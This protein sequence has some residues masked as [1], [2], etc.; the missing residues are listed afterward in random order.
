MTEEQLNLLDALKQTDEYSS[1]I[2]GTYSFRGE[3][4]ETEVLPRLQSL[5]VKNTTVL[6]DTEKYKNTD[7]LVHAGNKYYLDHVRCPQTFHP[8]FLLLLG[9]RRGYCLVGS[10]NLSAAGWQH[11]AELMTEF[12]YNDADSD[13]E[14]AAVFDQL[15]G[16]IDGITTNSRV[17]SDK[18]Q[19]AIEEAMRD[20]P[21]LEEASSTHDASNVA[22]IDNLSTPIIDQ[23]SERIPQQ[24]ITEIEVISPYFS[25]NDIQVIQSLCQLNPDRLILN[26]Q[27]NRVQGFDA[28][29]IIDAVP[30]STEL[31]VQAIT[32]GE[33]ENRLIHGKL[34]MLRGTEDVWSLYGSPNLTTA[35]LALPATAGN[36]ELAVLRHET[37]PDYFD[38]LLD[39][40]VINRS[41][42]DPTAI[43]YEPYDTLDDETSS[44]TL[45]LS[46]AH[47]ETDGLLILGVD[48]FTAE[49]I[50]IHLEK[51]QAETAL[52]ISKTAVEVVDGTLE[53]Q[54]ERIP[55]FC[56]GATQVWL[57]LHVE[58][59]EQHTDS[60]WIARPSLEVTPRTSEV[61]QIEASKGRNGLIDL[62][63]RLEGIHAMYDFLD[64]LDIS[65]GDID[66]DP[67]GGGGGGNNDGVGGDGIDERTVTESN[68]VFKNKV[69]AFHTNLESATGELKSDK[70][71]RSQLADVLDIF[72][73]GSKFTFWWVER[74]SSA[75]HNLIHVRLGMKD[76]SEFISRIRRQEGT[77][78]VQEF[79]REQRLLEHIAIISY[80]L[81]Q[82]LQKSKDIHGADAKVYAIFQESIK[83]L[84][85][86]CAANRSEPILSDEALSDCL[87]EYDGLETRTPSPSRVQAFCKQILYEA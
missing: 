13:A 16:F 80:Y 50:T 45:N 85:Q 21:W 83:S 32:V 8:K 37:R 20:A 34:V 48:D 1:A 44:E 47:L 24:D 57:T 72:I 35:A 9:H 36:I 3:F 39:D 78:V 71:W 30:N 38:Y 26:V 29:A 76:L 55:T 79:E 22:L 2:L 51:Q 18:T 40:S 74:D 33:D 23:V 81:D 62:L 52:D 4:F 75:S 56:D 58:G 14:T 87:D 6:T 10:A 49:R 15:A 63:N 67:G 46:A 43:S 64:G 86:T 31:T 70:T 42:V 65:H 73:G 61:K 84:L 69:E 59:E 11:N 25:G 60:R 66:I 68:D 27:Q 82:L 19:G 28:T 12:K 53:I 77:K 7:D 17:P 54:D 5:G 41:I